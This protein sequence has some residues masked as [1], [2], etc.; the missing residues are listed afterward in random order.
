[1]TD[2]QLDLTN[3][4]MKVEA[5]IRHTPIRDVEARMALFRLQDLLRGWLLLTRQSKKGATRGGQ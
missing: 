3:D 1:M 2:T 4:L 5:R